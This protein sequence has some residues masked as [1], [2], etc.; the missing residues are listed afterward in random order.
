MTIHEAKHYQSEGHFKKG[1]MGPK[2]RSAIFFLEHGGKKV[3]I[4]NIKHMR[5]AVSG[6]AGT[7]IIN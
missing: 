3:V 1:S 7:Q 2:M 6:N 5:K 4:T